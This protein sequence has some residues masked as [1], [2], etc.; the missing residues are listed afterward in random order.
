MADKHDVLQAL[1]KGLVGCARRNRGILIVV[2]ICVHIKIL[3]QLFR[4]K[5]KK[6]EARFYSL[7][8][9]NFR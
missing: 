7:Y 1:A 9:K 4:E 6:R 5:N 3:A 2:Y 8:W